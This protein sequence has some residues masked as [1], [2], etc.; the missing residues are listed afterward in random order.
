MSLENLISVNFTE[1]EKTRITDALATLEEAFSG[2]TV[3]LT[4]EERQR[5]GKLGNRTENFLEKVKGYMETK[6]EITPFYLDKDEFKNDY[7]ARQFLK[8]VRNRLNSLTEGADD[9]YLLLGTDQYNFS[10]AYYRNVKIVA[11]SNVPGTSSIYQD[12]SAQ[13]PGRPSEVPEEPETPQN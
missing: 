12:L 10:L 9:T 7:D 6:P 8:G 3:N 5:Y 2:K 13:F 11:A 1:E 4:P